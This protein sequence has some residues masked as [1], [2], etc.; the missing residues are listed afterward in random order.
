M[1]DGTFIT[2]TDYMEEDNLQKLLDNKTCSF[3]LLVS[4]N[5]LS[6]IKHEAVVHEKTEQKCRCKWC[7]KSYSNINALRQSG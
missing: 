1:L 3:C 7:E 5:K 4:Q 2:F 6:R